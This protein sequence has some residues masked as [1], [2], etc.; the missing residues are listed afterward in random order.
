MNARTP[1]PD[2]HGGDDVLLQNM[3]RLKMADCSRHKFWDVPFFLLV[4][5]SRLDWHLGET[6]IQF[7]ALSEA[8]R[9]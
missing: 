7:E 4:R 1:Q 3:G 8:F 9:M 6:C 5:I 2:V